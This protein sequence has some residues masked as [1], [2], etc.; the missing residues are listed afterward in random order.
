MLREDQIAVKKKK[1]NNN[2]KTSELI[3]IPLA[4]RRLEIWYNKNYKRQIKVSLSVLLKSS[5]DIW[6]FWGYEYVFFQPRVVCFG[7]CILWF[8]KTLTYQLK[9]G[10]HNIHCKVNGTY[11]GRENRHTYVNCLINGI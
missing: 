2:K 9:K 11:E 5:K 3:D 10:N 1:K 8:H 7:R 6:P 4:T